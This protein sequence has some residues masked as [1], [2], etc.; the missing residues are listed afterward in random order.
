MGTAP[1]SRR[2]EGLASR[3]ADEALD[4]RLQAAAAALGVARPEEDPSV[5]GLLVALNAHLAADPRA[6]KAWLV[7]TAF[8]AA[9]PRTE[10]V[11][12]YLRLLELLTPDELAISML[13]RTLVENWSSRRRRRVRVLSDA[14]VID[15]NTCAKTE[16]HTGI[17]RVVRESVP[18]WAAAH[19]DVVPLAWTAD[20]EGLRTLTPV[21][22]DRV[23]AWNEQRHVGRREEPANDQ[24]VVVPWRCHV[25]LPEVPMPELCPQLSCLA[26]LSGN[27]VSAIGY[28]AIPILSADIRPPHEPDNYVRYLTVVKHCTRVA[29]ISISAALEFRGFSQMLSAEGLAGPEV[30][31]VVLPAEAPKPERAVGDVDP[32]LVLCV[33]SQEVHKNHLAILQA[34]EVLWVEGHEFRLAFV[35]GPGWDPRP[36][37]DRVGELTRAGRPVA[38]HRGI[39]D[40]QMWELYGTARFTVF[41][42]LHEGYGL[43]VAES[44][45]CG[46]PVVTSCYGSMSEIAQNGGCLLAD[47]RD[48]ESLVEAMRRLMVDDALLQRLRDEARERPV[49]RWDEY[50]AEAWEVLVGS[51]PSAVGAAR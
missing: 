51:G 35:G 6:D 40:R 46:T 30:A 36:F 1:V 22:H 47:P 27:T 8:R 9:Y 14:V 37:E 43:P 15:V 21:E 7:L 32:P 17:Q 49:R 45:A 20:H 10:D 34:A 18:R 23:M 28:D 50:A 24:E 12:E 16:R 31:E 29:A 3:A 42:S 39:S 41:P 2:P 11:R 33:G 38:I 25:V 19:P 44:L 13:A 48:D 26:M 5:G 4:D